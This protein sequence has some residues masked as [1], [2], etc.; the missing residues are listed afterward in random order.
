MN[1]CENRG[2]HLVTI[3]SR[4]R[5]RAEFDAEDA[6]VWELAGEAPVWI[7]ATDGKGPLE[8][9]DGTFYTWITGEPLTFD[10][11]SAGQPNNSPTSC[12]ENTQCSCNEGIC[13]EHCAFLWATEGVDPTTVPGWNDRLCEHLIPS[14]CE[15][16]E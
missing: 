3:S 1:D 15:W 8:P 4:D 9:G 6:F 2:A 7:G 13:Y 5:T 12:A 10:A 11:W 16:D 14:V